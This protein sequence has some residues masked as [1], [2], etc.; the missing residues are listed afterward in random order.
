[1][2]SRRRRGRP[3][4]ATAAVAG[5]G[6]REDVMVVLLVCAAGHLA[7]AAND[8]YKACEKFEQVKQQTRRRRSRQGRD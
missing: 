5:Q 4:D 2:S 1:M 8:V 6:G 7:I 3:K